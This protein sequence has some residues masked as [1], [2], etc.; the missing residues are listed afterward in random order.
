MIE[1]LSKVMISALV[2]SNFLPILSKISFHMKKTAV[3][4]SIS[5]LSLPELYKNIKSF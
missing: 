1:R 4:V 3:I 2:C 5:D